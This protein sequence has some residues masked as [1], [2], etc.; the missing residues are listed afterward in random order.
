MV[1]RKIELKRRYGRKK[2]IA[3][4]KLKL[5]LAKDGA[6]KAKI[7]KKILTISPWW[8]PAEPVAAAK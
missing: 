6:E 4:L 2:K 8:K 5:L 7:T 3:K 1:E